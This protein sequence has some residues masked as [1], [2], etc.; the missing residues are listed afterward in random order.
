MSTTSQENVAM[1]D[2]LERE[3]SDL[4]REHRGDGETGRG[5]NGQPH[6]N[7]GDA[8]RIVSGVS[9]GLLVLLGLSRKSLP[10]LALAGVGGA[11]LYRGASGHCAIL[12][13]FG[14]DH[15]HGEG[16]AKPSEYFHRSLHVEQ[17]MTINKSAEELYR[18][19]HNFE[20][21]PRFMYYL[22][23]VKV[24]DERRSHWVVKGPA[25]TRP[26]WD[27]EI[28][29][30]EPNSLIAW[31]SVGST[32]VDNSGSVRFVEAPAGRGTEVRIV[33]DYIPPAGRLGAAIAKLL[34]RDAK[35]EI[36]EDLRRFKRLM[37][38]GEVP[39][40]VGQPR[41]TCSGSGY[42]QKVKIA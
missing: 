41:G 28:I 13:Q 7:V 5:E 40:T 1:R 25:G 17:A 36:Q 12:E 33:V 29:N 42:R 6:V 15:A 14:I 9:G 35:G 38:T 18:F 20:N 22:E 26:E 19:W 2:R 3:S 4:N 21:L 8:E 24:I 34:G 30:D 37:E 31:R 11:L 16:S 27:A 10:G 39:T 23:S 32:H